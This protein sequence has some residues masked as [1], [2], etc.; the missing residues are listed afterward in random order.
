MPVASWAGHALEAWVARFDLWRPDLFYS[1]GDDSA[2][3]WCVFVLSYDSAIQRYPVVSTSSTLRLQ[4][5]ADVLVY[6]ACSW[7]ARSRASVFSLKKAH[8]AG[9]CAVACSPHSEFIVATGKMYS[10]TIMIAQHRANRSV[11]QAATMS[12]CAC[13]MSGIWSGH[14]S[15]PMCPVVA[16]CGVFPGTPWT[17][18][19]SCA[20]ACRTGSPS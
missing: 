4:L 16:A 8:G 2:F 7:D 5:N 13:G 9:V 20:H 14:C 10:K 6:Q 19:S 3:C 1:G 12:I 11:P 15:L 18:R 17:S